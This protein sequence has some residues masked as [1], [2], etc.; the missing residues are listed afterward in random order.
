MNGSIFDVS[1]NPR[2]YGPGGMYGF[3]AGK[4]AA[5]AFVTGCF[6]QDLTPD[7]SGVEE[8]FI[9]VD[10]E[11]DE[12]EKKLSRGHKKIRREQDLRFAR[13]Q[14]RKQV[15]HWENFYRN[16]QKYF[17]VGKVDASRGGVRRDEKLPLCESAMKNRPK[18]KTAKKKQDE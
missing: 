6:E 11:N 4:D 10:D 16:S 2:I 15:L 5:R 13:A 14:V 18:R 9:P 3:F 17:E 1:A 8:M 12:E 7:L